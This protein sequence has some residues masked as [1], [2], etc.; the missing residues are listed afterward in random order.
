M[1]ILDLLYER[2]MLFFVIK[3][4]SQHAAKEVQFN[5]DKKIMGV[6]GQVEIT[7]LKIFKKLRYLAP[8]KEIT[9]FI[10]MVETFFAR[11]EPTEIEVKIT[12]LDD[13]GEA[14]SSTVIHH[15]FSIY[16]DIGYIN[17]KI[18]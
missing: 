1:V 18:S 5:F 9:V 4:N 10:D 16:E 8:Q 12:W 7:A 14:K 15:D 17:H 6:D 11:E 13:K 2:G 3:N